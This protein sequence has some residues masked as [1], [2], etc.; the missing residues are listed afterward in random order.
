MEKDEQTSAYYREFGQRVK[1]V[2]TNRGLTQAELAAQLG[3]TRS[4]IANLESGRQRIHVHHLSRLMV[5]LQVGSDD[6]LPT[7]NNLLSLDE[8]PY[9]AS[10]WEV[11]ETARQFVLD[12]LRIATPRGRNGAA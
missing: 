9:A 12:S 5:V 8:G 3:L 1:N 7:A 4:S 10:T 2:R 6:L 11:S